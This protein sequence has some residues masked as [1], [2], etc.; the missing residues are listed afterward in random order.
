[1]KEQ[2]ASGVITQP[3][4]GQGSGTAARAFTPMKASFFWRTPAPTLRCASPTQNVLTSGNST[5]VLGSF[6]ARPA[7]H[8]TSALPEGTAQQREQSAGW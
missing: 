7:A 6:T 8:T 2:D 5:P 3:V 4:C 1:M